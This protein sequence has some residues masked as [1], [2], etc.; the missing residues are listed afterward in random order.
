MSHHPLTRRS[1]QA[2]C[3]KVLEMPTM[4]AS[5]SLLVCKVAGPSAAENNEACIEPS[6]WLPVVQWTFVLGAR[7]TQPSA[8]VSA[9]LSYRNP[10]LPAST[11]MRG[12]SHNFH[13]RSLRFR[14]CHSSK[15]KIPLDFF[16]RSSYSAS[17]GSQRP[18]WIP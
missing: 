13:P 3:E 7:R 14:S 5:G 6:I 16:H 9:I 2:A 8:L 18:V 4:T 10:S 11:F 17:L 15:G 12:M 1:F